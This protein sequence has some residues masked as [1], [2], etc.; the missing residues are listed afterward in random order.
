LLIFGR[1]IYARTYRTDY[2]YLVL[3]LLSNLCSQ[4]QFPVKTPFQSHGPLPQLVEEAKEEEAKE[5]KAP[6][7]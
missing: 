1:L 4:S 5:E 7:D 6:P 2:D 3:E